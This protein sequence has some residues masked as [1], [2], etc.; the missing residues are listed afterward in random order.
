MPESINIYS[1]DLR[2]TYGINRCVNDSLLEIISIDKKEFVSAVITIRGNS[3]I[4]R[5][6]VFSIHATI[7]KDKGIIYDTLIEHLLPDDEEDRELMLNAMF[8]EADMKIL[9]KTGEVSL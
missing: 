3:A 7:N 6:P 4:M 9:M 5:K 8:F 1:L 2:I